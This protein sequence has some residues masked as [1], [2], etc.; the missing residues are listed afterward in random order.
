MNT[1]SVV[2]QI[3]R[4]LTAKGLSAVTWNAL[5]TR[6]SSACPQA[7]SMVRLHIKIGGVVAVCVLLHIQP[8]AR[9]TVRESK[10]VINLSRFLLT[11]GTARW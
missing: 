1:V 4:K 11:G 5:H 6:V 10:V 2:V 3:A 9:N 8:S 7:L